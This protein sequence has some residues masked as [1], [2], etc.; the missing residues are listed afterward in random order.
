MNLPRIDCANLQDMQI[1][2]W[3]LIIS[4]FHIFALSIK[5]KNAGEVDTA[6]SEIKDFIIKYR[7]KGAGGVN[8]L[9]G[10]G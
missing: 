2:P 4:F 10:S 6:L 1:K 9:A 7:G 5:K 8:S 3:F